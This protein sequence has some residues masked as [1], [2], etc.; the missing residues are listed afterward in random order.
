MEHKLFLQKIFQAVDL[1]ETL[2]LEHPEVAADVEDLVAE[3][4]RGRVA[5]RRAGQAPGGK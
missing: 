4:V 1:L 3:L 2:A 5:A